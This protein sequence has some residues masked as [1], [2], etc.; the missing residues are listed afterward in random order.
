MEVMCKNLPIRDCLRES[1]SLGP[2]ALVFAS[3]FC[4]ILV[5]TLKMDVLGSQH[6]CHAC[7]IFK[8]S[9]IIAHMSF[10]IGFG[11]YLHATGRHDRAR[12]SSQLYRSYVLQ[13]I[14]NSETSTTEVNLAYRTC[15]NLL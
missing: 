13:N 10:T 8:G 4:L 3:A 9:W 5:V 6:F 7:R 1:H 14:A 11:E 12:A 15:D 2:P